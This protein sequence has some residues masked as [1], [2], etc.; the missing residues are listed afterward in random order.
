MEN[1]A[2]GGYFQLELYGNKTFPY[3]NLIHL[4]TARNCLEYI[5]RTRRYEKIYLPY[6]T[7]DVLLE[8]INKVNIDYQFYDIDDS[9]EPIFDYN[10]IG[11]NEAFLIT[12]YF[13]IK[14]QFIEDLSKKNKNLIVDNAQAF[15][16]EPSL[17]IDTFYSPRKF[18]GV[19]DGGFLA[20]N[21]LL[22]NSLETDY[23]CDRMSHLLKRIDS[24]AEDGYPDFVANDKI[25]ENQEIKLMSHLTR[26]I[27]L[28]IDFERIKKQR[29]E[30]YLFL[31]EHLKSSNFLKI[32]LDQKDV[33]MVYPYR[34]K[35]AKEIR[36]IL[37]AKKIYCATYWPNVLE[38]SDYSVNSYHLTSEIIA[39]PIDQRY[40]QSD[41]IKIIEIINN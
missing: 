34:V 30:N 41:M 11:E 26:T 17:E 7:C 4:N 33:P 16:A 40:N 1:K 15:F 13:G 14:T 29:R 18:V 10:K 9:L 20:T 35:N 38:W 24:S 19:S 27:L 28:S 32:E 2:I 21:Q 36:N 5:L 22:E 39:L 12:N 23:S 3:S 6:F 37:I 25:L 8:P 31:N